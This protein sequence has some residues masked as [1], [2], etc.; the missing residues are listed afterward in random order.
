MQFKDDRRDTRA[1]PLDVSVAVFDHRFPGS[2]GFEAFTH[3]A[4]EE[5]TLSRGSIVFRMDAFGGPAVDHVIRVRY[6]RSALT[7]ALFRVVRGR[8]IWVAGVEACMKLAPRRVAVGVPTDRIRRSHRL[9]WG[10]RTVYLDAACPKGRC[11]DRAPNVGLYRH[12]RST[13]DV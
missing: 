1:S 8:R 5:S 2:W 10:V 11:V 9:R 12:P 7:C 6:R 4:W 3:E 13:R